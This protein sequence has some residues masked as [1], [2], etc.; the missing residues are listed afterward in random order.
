[1]RSEQSFTNCVL[2][3]S[4]TPCQGPPA[5]VCPE[6]AQTTSRRLVIISTQPLL[7]SSARLLRYRFASLSSWFSSANFSVSILIYVY[8]FL[9][10]YMIK[11]SPCIV[12]PKSQLISLLGHVL[13]VLGQ[14]FD[15]WFLKEQVSRNS[16]HVETVPRLL[17]FIL[18]V[19]WPWS[20]PFEVF[21]CL[22]LGWS[23]LIRLRGAPHLLELAKTG[24][25]G[26]FLTTYNRK[27]EL[28]N[29]NA[30]ILLNNFHQNILNKGFDDAFGINH[31]LDKKWVICKGII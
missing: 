1:M 3:L 7:W 27:E 24:L 30:G 6:T 17:S 26:L 8:Y 10:K 25:T 4:A 13:Q 2:C 29:S 12:K 14:Q 15:F 20:L 18:S 23:L 22:C 21:D 9:K 16:L 28:C 19:P 31:N 11:N 5:P